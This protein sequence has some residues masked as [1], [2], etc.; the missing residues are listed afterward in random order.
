MRQKRL[1]DAQK[2][3]RYRTLTRVILDKRDND[4]YDTEV[5]AQ[6]TELLQLN[7]EFNAIWNYR[8][9]IMGAI[10]DQLTLKFWDEE[11]LLTMMLLKGYPK[12]Y[13]IWNHRLWCLENYPSSDAR[14]WQTE[15][16][17]VGKVLDKDARN[18]HGWHYRRIVIQNLEKVTGQSLNTEQFDF[19][20]KKVNENISNFSAWHQRATLIPEMIEQGQIREPIQ[21]INQE[22]QYIINAIFTD[23]EDQSVWFYIKWFITNNCTVSQLDSNQYARLL[24]ELKDAIEAINQ[25]ELEFLGKDNTWC[26]KLL[27]VIEKIQIE[28]L[29]ISVNPRAV[30]YM[31]RLCE[32]DPLRKN[33]YLAISENN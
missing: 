22:F 9:D 12:V 7:P 23:A 32:A 15:L 6:T 4:D 19:T 17:M 8:R 29:K 28:K 14:K 1:K 24:Q 18:F 16:L 21:F 30:E 11:L 13:W 33:R 31:K 27:V 26:L 10:K 20:T 5:L 25:D 3:A 2:I